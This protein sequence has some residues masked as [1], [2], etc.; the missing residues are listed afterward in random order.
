MKKLK[1]NNT[2]H[3][4]K[5]FNGKIFSIIVLAL[6]VFLA[7]SGTIRNGFIWDDDD[8]IHKN[9][10][11]TDP[12]GLAKIWK[13]YYAPKYSPEQNT[14]QYYPLV[15]TTFYLEHKLWGFNPAGY[16]TTNL[17]LHIAN[18]IL[19]LFLLRKFGLGWY[20][21]LITAA[22]FGIHP[23]QVESVAWATERKNVLA[24]LFFF[25]AFLS[26]LHY[27]ETTQKKYY[28]ASIALFIC[29]LLSKTAIVFFPV[30]LILAAYLKERPIVKTIILAIPFFI[31]SAISGLVTTLVEHGMVG[32]KG[33]EWTFPPFQRLLI[34]SHSFWFYILKMLWP[35]PIS[36]LYGQ[37][38]IDTN[39][40][41]SYLPL[42]AAVALVAAL[43]TF[44]KKLG[45]LPAFSVAYFFV[46]A[47][48]ALGFISFYMMRYTFVADHFI[49]MAGWAIMLLA[50][51][52][53]S[54][55]LNRLP[56]YPK[57]VIA[58]FV[59]ILALVFCTV[60]TA[61]QVKKYKNV[62]T[63]WEHT[64]KV[65]P[66]ACLAYNNLAWLMATNKDVAFY[67]PQKAVQLAL[68]ACELTGYRNAGV[69]DTLAVSYAA[70]DRFPDAVATAEKALNLANSAADKQLADTIQQHLDLYMKNQPYIETNPK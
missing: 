18:T 4:K 68:R 27:Q 15:F 57:I 52:A 60:L 33:S 37:W 64:I 62:Q 53:I 3:A 41:V 29:A 39:S 23:V 65:T 70:A 38:K 9:P 54:K 10:L 22:L 19:L 47:A 30:A 44:R 17:I 12:A 25:S 13:S 1:T 46:A 58:T 43:I 26:F 21:S 20:V 55:L 34:V 56:Q 24:G 14:P 8:Y 63:L 36:F 7:F 42:I 48:P 31:L 2:E 11:L 67:N 69:L 50:V 61:E 6:L 66:D 5:T 35:Y 45:K 28:I 49:Y 32:A 51:F 40:I 59:T 16:H